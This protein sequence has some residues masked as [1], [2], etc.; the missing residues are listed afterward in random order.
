MLAG[1]SLGTTLR[2]A[3][4]LRG[5]SLFGSRILLHGHWGYLDDII[6]EM[7]GA[8][9]RITAAHFIISIKFYLNY[10]KSIKDV[11]LLFITTIE[12]TERTT[13]IN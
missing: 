10:I 11:N 2:S 6:T 13:I 1:W 3:W 4:R 9:S 7:Y 5:I 12:V 8:G